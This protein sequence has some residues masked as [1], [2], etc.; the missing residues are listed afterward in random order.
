MKKNGWNFIVYKIKLTS[1][2]LLPLIFSIILSN[3]LV[4]STFPSSAKPT[5]NSISLS[6]KWTWDEP[7]IDG[8]FDTLWSICPS[9]GYS[10]FSR[11]GGNQTFWL[12]FL[13]SEDYLF[14]AISWSDNEGEHTIPLD[15]I[16]I[17]WSMRALF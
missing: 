12:K 17:T 6:S 10:I 9:Y 11:E 13:N 7:S 4:I 14:I 8:T 5:H 1:F 16:G 15:G 3:L 2:K